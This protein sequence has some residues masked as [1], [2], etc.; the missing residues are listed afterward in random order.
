MSHQEVKQENKEQEGNVEV[1]AKVRGV[2]GF[3]LEAQAREAGEPAREQDIERLLTEADDW[4]E[5]THEDED[6][7]G[8]PLGELV[9]CICKDLGLTPEWAWLAAY[10][11]DRRPTER[12]K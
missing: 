8:R 5:A 11:H 2:L 3:V 12:A 7:T 10:Y 9:A 1:K 6:V 4:L